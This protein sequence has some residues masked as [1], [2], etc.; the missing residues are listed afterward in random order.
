MGVD[1][2][3]LFWMSTSFHTTSRHL[4]IAVLDALC[5]K[6]HSVTVIKKQVDNESEVL[7]SELN[8]K[9][10]TTFSI[11]V[12]SSGKSNLI[13]RYISDI[14]YISACDKYLKTQQYDA[15]FVQSS[16]VAGLMFRKLEKKQPN[17]IKTFNVQDTFP[18]NA[19]ISGVLKEKSLAY[20]ILRKLQIYAY[21][22]SDHI[23]TISEDMKQFLIEACRVAPENVSVVYNWSYRDDVYSDDDFERFALSDLLPSK[24]FNVVYAGNLGL[25]QNVDI[26]I[27][28]ANTLKN[29]KDIRF[30]IF[31]NGVYRDKLMMKVKE[32]GCNNVYFLPFQS[33]ELAPSIYGLANVNIIPLK[34]DIYKTALP[35]KTATCL[36][37]GKPIIL[38]IGRDSVFGHKLQN[39]T[40]CI[41]VDSDDS[42]QLVSAINRIKNENLSVHTTE[43]YK[44]YFSCSVNSKKYADII[45]DNL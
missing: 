6:G 1:L 3:V 20:M 23:I 22:H 33:V 10:I 11:P 34:K 32:Y 19:R 41:L 9:N 15:V 28:A 25:M 31:G 8:D 21:F 29:D 7:P 24:S 45:T 5:E 16:N 37:C 30:C 36:A 42:N 39:N 40:G 18:E 14:K 26:V 38:A 4:L 17:A 27:E 13:A 43:Y 2:K 44:A 35:S 12:K